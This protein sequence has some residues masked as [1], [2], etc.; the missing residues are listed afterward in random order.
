MAIRSEWL[1]V[2]LVLKNDIPVSGITYF[3]MIYHKRWDSHTIVIRNFLVGNFASDIFMSWAHEPN[4]WITREE[5][6]LLE[7]H[8][9]WNTKW[10]FFR[11][12]TY[13][14]FE[15]LTIMIG[16]DNEWF[17]SGIFTSITTKL[18]ITIGHCHNFLFVS[19]NCL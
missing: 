18:L 5:F 13:E 4:C 16:S 19:D 2:R 3:Y 8:F 1:I 6:Y 12:E 14:S 10:L 15:S 7:F 17:H 11:E 9:E